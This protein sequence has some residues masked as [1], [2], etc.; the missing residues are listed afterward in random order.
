[1]HSKTTPM[2]HNTML[3]TNLSRSF[4]APFPTAYIS[5]QYQIP[6]CEVIIHTMVLIILAN[7][8][9]TENLQNS[10][11]ALAALLFFALLTILTCGNVCI[12]VLPIKAEMFVLFLYVSQLI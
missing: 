11:C 8:I 1:M 3:A 5:F 2:Q 6:T 4:A 12:I 9:K 7:M 10:N